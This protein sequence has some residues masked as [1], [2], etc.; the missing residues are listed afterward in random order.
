MNRVDDTTLGKSTFPVVNIEKGAVETADEWQSKLGL[1]VSKHTYVAAYGGVNRD[2]EAGV[3]TG[4]LSTGFGT[5]PTAFG[6]EYAF[7]MMLERNLE[8][9][10]LIIKTAWGGK[11]LNYDFSPLPQASIKPLQMKNSRQKNGRP[12]RRRGTNTSPTEELPL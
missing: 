12:R 6:P 4:P 9:P 8:Q 11:S 7:G 10:V 3:A 5:R 2:A 1:P